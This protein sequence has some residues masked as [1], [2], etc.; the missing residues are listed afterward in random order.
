MVKKN[1]FSGIHILV[2]IILLFFVKY[3][4]A[5][6]LECYDQQ[7]IDLNSKKYEPFKSVDKSSTFEKKFF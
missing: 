7:W 5:L 1:L 3:I 2:Y 6:K 4:L